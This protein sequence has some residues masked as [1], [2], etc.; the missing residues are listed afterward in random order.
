MFYGQTGTTKT[1]AGCVEV[2][3]NEALE[4]TPV[5]WNVQNTIILV[6]CGTG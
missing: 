3:N 1:P 4:L 6:L 5:L 2:A